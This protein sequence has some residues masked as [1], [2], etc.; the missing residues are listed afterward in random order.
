METKPV[1]TK[2]AKC[3]ICGHVTATVN[4]MRVH[5]NTTHGKTGRGLTKDYISQTT[6]PPTHRKGKS[7]K[8]KFQCTICGH[9]C[10]SDAGI[11]GHIQNKHGKS[12]SIREFYKKIESPAKRKYTKREKPST[13]NVMEML[14]AAGVMKKD[15][16]FRMT[17][18]LEIN[19]TKNSIDI[20]P[21][22]PNRPE[23]A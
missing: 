12:G 13:N 10:R 7:K 4:A 14:G 18:D 20:L 16:K 19:L 3:K 22:S 15:I 9:T 2:N 1:K 5:L 11:I 17:V 6:A 8:S 21:W 23:G